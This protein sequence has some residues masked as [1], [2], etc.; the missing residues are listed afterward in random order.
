MKVAL[1]A[2]AALFAGASPALAQGDPRVEN[3]NCQGAFFFNRAPSAIIIVQSVP[4]PVATG[5]ARHGRPAPTGFVSPPT[6]GG[7]G[8]G[9]SA[10]PVSGI[11]SITT[12]GIGSMTTTGIGTMTGLGIGSIGTSGFVLPPASNAPSPFAAPV[13]SIPAPGAL[14]N[15][16]APPLPI[17]PPLFVAVCP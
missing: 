16:V 4:G 7:S 12:S 5:T 10:G 9:S 14:K 3:D 8:I 13:T 11:G 1:F 2:A 17:A 6:S 15:A